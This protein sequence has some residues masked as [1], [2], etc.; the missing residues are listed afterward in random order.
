MEKKK[1]LRIITR[2]NNGGPAKQAVW[3]TSKLPDKGYECRLIT[4]LSE[5]GED[6]ITWFAEEYNVEYTLL[7]DLKRSISLLS[8][9]RTASSILR[10]VKEWKPQIV[11]THMSK[12]GLVGRMAVRLYNIFRKEKIIT[13]HT[14][15]GH[16]FHSYFGKLK[17]KLF[18]FLERYLAKKTDAIVA[19]SKNQKNELLYTY[20]IGSYAKIREI[21]LGIDFKPLQKKKNDHRHIYIGM[22]GRIAEVKNYPLA[23]EIAEAIKK[24]KLP[25]SITIAGGGDNAKLEE[26]RSEIKELGLEDVISFIG[27][28][29][30]PEQ[31]WADKDFAMITSYNE[32]TP[33]SLIESMFCGIPYIASRVGGIPDMVEGTVNQKKENLYIYNNCVQVGS[34]NAEDYVKAIA[35]FLHD[36]G[37]RKN[38]GKASLELSKR[39][40]INRLVDDIDVLYSQLAAE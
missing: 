12:A 17:T 5:A 32:G 19:I 6:S 30:S 33:V 13:V 29:D 26:Y 15:H 23:I 38:A 7:S 27:N 20:R 21:P 24:E 37:F 34:H 16:V 2:L 36:S 10:I 3:L 31:F 14:F 35:L 8:D 9:I 28:I 39:Y 40:S 4:G 18:I 22:M 11:H 1:V 25:C